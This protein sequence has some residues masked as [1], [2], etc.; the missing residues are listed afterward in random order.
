[1]TA[2]CCFGLVRKAPLDF[3]PRRAPRMECARGGLEVSFSEEWHERDAPEL[4][5]PCSS[6]H[7]LNRLIESMF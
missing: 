5:E 7:Y 1:M 4:Y 3:I 2:S 6:P